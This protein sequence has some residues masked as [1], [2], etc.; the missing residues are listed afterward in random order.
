MKQTEL[1]LLGFL[2]YI[3]SIGLSEALEDYEKRKLGIFNLLNFFQVITGILVPLAALF[4]EKRLPGMAWLI[5]CAPAFISILVLWLNA[6]RRQEVALIAYFILYPVATSIVYLSGMNLGTELSF[7]LYGILSVFFIQELS[8]MLFS[9]GLSMISY[10]MLAVVWNNYPYQLAKTNELFYLFNQVLAIVFIF[11]GL[12]L[13]KKENTGYQFSII[14]RNR[15]LHAKNL[16]IEM[17]KKEIAD[18]AELLQSQKAKLTE[19]NALKNKLFSVIAHDLKSPIYALHSLFRNMQQYDLPAE[20]IKSMIPD[21]VNDLN[22][23][24]G[25]MENL[26]QWARSQMQ[27]D[28]VKLQPIDLSK[29]T[30][31]VVQLLRLQ[32]EA[33]QLRI[34]SRLNG[35][36]LAMADKDM[37]NLVL[38]NL[39]SNAIKFT[40]A[41]GTISIDMNEMDAFI[42]VSVEDSGVGI[43]PET[44][45]KINK[46]DYYT[47]MGTANESGTG[48]GLMLCKEFLIRNGGQLNIESAP[49]KGSIFSFTLP[50]VSQEP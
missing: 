25:L 23:T 6:T 42:E 32:A 37:V 5:A 15:D 48:L 39:L 40:P 2:Q 38:R 26:L 35:P 16:E 46:N 17:Q 18:N 10:F 50:K 4:G 24:T 49:G 22:F 27:Q 11:Y 45:K 12:F 34:E 47:S 8:H 21:V 7:I 19:L 43:T 41:R 44:L 1:R 3:K 13:I 14:A 29:M 33:K 36:V 31:D 30:K 28:T 20:D 9:L